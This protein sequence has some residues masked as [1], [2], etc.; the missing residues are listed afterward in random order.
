MKDL[1]NCIPSTKRIRLRARNSKLE[2]P[3]ER[4][5]CIVIEFEDRP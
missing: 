4:K 1:F 2:K 3:A 5:A